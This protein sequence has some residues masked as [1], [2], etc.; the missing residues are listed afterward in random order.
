MASDLITVDEY[1]K[2]TGQSSQTLSQDDADQLAWA[3]TSASRVIRNYLDRDLTLA[4][5][6]SPG[7]RTFRYT[8]GNVLEI[9]DAT[10]ITSVATTITPWSPATRTLDPSEWVA[11][12]TTANLPVFD[13]V[14]LWTNLPFAQSP[15]MG[16]Q[17][18]E[19]RYGWRPHPL[20]LDVT[21][22]WGWPEFPQD[23]KQAAIWQ[24]TD[25]MAPETPYVSESIEGYSHSFRETRSNASQQANPITAVTPRAQSLLDPYVRVNV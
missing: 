5:D 16:F 25:I 11:A 2:A 24:T 1:K 9:D 14:E 4:A 22:T 15:A 12:A 13:A 23:I 17:W 10:A 21:A 6:A 18:N 8:G 19:D 20:S 3:I 7:A